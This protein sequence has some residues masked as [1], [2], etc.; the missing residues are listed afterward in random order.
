[1][2]MT[3]LSILDIRSAF[4]FSHFP[5]SAYTKGEQGKVG[6]YMAMWTV[7]LSVRPTIDSKMT[8]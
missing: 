4:S 6:T 2:W 5:F 3:Y 8:R 7:H 1:M